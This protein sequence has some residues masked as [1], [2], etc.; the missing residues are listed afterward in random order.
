M[1]KPI[2]YTTTKGEK[3]YKIS[4][5]GG[6]DAKGR[7]VTLKK[8][9]FKTTREANLWAARTLSNIEE[10]GLPDQ[11]SENRTVEEAFDI[12]FSQYKMTVQE[13]SY[14]RVE[15]LYR[16][17]I[18][19]L[20]GHRKIS[21]LKKED[22]QELIFYLFSVQPKTYRKNYNYFTKMLKESG[23]PISENHFF[24]V[25]VKSK[26]QKK[27]FT[28]DELNTVLE[29]LKDNPN[30][31]AYPFLRL[32]AYTG[33]RKAEAA[34][35]EKKNVN[36]KDGYIV[37]DQAFSRDANNKI[38]MGAGKNES[39]KRTIPIDKG[40]LDAI[41]ALNYDSPLVFGEF[42]FTNGPRKWLREACAKT[43][44]EPISIHGLRHT[45]CSLLFEAGASVKEVQTRLGHS[46]PQMTLNVYTHI[47]QQT[48][49]KTALKFVNYMDGN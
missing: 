31:R 48:A 20:V 24:P 28:R 35:L 8:Q 12:W 36:I 9:G 29:A 44:I 33:L 10:N 46:T 6:L 38:I 4:I 15:K 18:L 41:L 5:Y 42:D 19:P 13:V 39:S 34:A 2:P 43:G 1:A 45:H 3:R 17:H 11:V 14:A 37:I 32:I 40:T 25:S 49:K 47:T 22:V 27:I 23:Y 7:Q 16:N 30:E 26:G 21:D